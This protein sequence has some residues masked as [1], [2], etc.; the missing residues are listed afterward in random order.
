MYGN[1]IP[2][3]G[4]RPNSAGRRKGCGLC[5]LPELAQAGI[6]HLKL[7]GRGNY[8]D[9]M[10]RDIRAVRLALNILDDVRDAGAYRKEMKR[11]LFAG[12]CPKQCYYLGE[13][14]L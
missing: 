8:A 13:Y 6:T 4:I 3:P 5:A 2:V 14:P 1:W 12:G 9:C 11:R 7:V 10:E